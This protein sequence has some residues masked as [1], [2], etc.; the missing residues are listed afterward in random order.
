MDKLTIEK[1]LSLVEDYKAR[2]SANRERM[3]KNDQIMLAY[4]Q[5]SRVV[6]CNQILK[7]I[8]IYAKEN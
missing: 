8:K 7:L 3:I 1:V 2:C 4:D 6:A 5:D